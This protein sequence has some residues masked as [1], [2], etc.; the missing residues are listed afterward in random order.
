MNYDNDAN[1]DI[2]VSSPFEALPQSGYMPVNIRITNHSGKTR[3]WDFTFISAINQY[4]LNSG[5]IEFNKRFTV[6]NNVE[7]IFSINVPIYTSG[8][9]RYYHQQ[10][11]GDISGFGISNRKIKFPASGPRYSSVAKTPYLLMSDVLHQQHWGL[12]NNYYNETVMKEQKSRRKGTKTKLVKQR[13][14]NIDLF[15]SSFNPGEF[16]GNWLGLTGI[17]CIWMTISDWSQLSAESKHALKTWLIQGG[18]LYFPGRETPSDFRA[19]N[20]QSNYVQIGAGFVRMVPVH[21]NNLTSL[22]FSESLTNTSRITDRLNAKYADAWP[23]REGVDSKPVKNFMIVGFI[24]VFAWVVGPLNLRSSRKK[25]RPMQLLWTTPL[26]AIIA[27]LILILL[28]IFQ[29]GVGGRGRRF[30]T[31]QIIPNIMTQITSQ[32]Q[33]SSTGILLSQKFR[34]DDDLY[35]TSLNLAQK[36]KIPHY[37]KRELNSYSVD[38][39]MYADDWFR[40]RQL[41]G[42]FLMKVDSTRGKIEIE[43]VSE[44]ESDILK[45]KSSLLNTLD[46]FYYIDASGQIWTCTNMRTGETKELIYADLDTF[47]KWF[48]SYQHYAGQN[49]G[50]ILQKANGK[51][52]YFFATSSAAKN[53]AIETSRH[54]RWQDEPVF[55]F[56]QVTPMVST[57]HE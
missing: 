12:L 34:G 21:Q 32:E 49:V 28:M 26:I 36:I 43:K 11:L 33:I 16:P 39:N 47:R 20:Q 6:K 8:V 23:L 44:N 56:G 46:K 10:I 14:R 53:V 50:K 37:Q 9:N 35:I 45:C 24:I 18:N 40:S 25:G 17:E 1:I 30:T 22:N 7:R 29:D 38:E 15:G 42:Q 27:S 52:N 41:Q 2:K 57:L 31:V 13:L 4:Q 19:I 48:N 5:K 54:I 3:H 51:S 55:Y